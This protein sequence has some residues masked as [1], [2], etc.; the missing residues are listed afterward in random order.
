M[1]NSFHHQPPSHNQPGL[2]YDSSSLSSVASSKAAFPPVLTSAPPSRPNS[3][4]QMTHLLHPSAQQGPSMPISTASPYSR[5][6]DSASGSPADRS[7]ILTDAPPL[8]GSLSESAG[9]VQAQMGGAVGQ[10]QQKR[11]YRQRRKDPSCDACRERKVKVSNCP[12]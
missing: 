1:M 12:V 6:Y 2:V 4:L 7:S 3:G 8:N 5:S 9:L 11:A 10:S